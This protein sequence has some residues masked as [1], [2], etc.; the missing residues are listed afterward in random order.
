M[1]SLKRL[2]GD[3]K[4]SK[5]IKRSEMKNLKFRAWDKFNG[6]YWYSDNYKNLADFFTRMQELID[7]KNELIFEQFT[8]LCDKNG[9]KIY[10]GDIMRHK[11]A[12][13]PEDLGF[14][15]IWNEYLFFAIRIRKNIDGTNEKSKFGKYFEYCEIIGNI[16]ENPELLN[17]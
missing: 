1:K 7:G 14:E 13:I 9:K 5:H 6:C 15:I 8:G 10:D 4:E 11:D 17:Q 12:T 2:V 3:L 16:H